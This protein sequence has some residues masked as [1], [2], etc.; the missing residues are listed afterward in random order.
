MNSLEYIAHGLVYALL[1][2]SPLART[3]PA[4]WLVCTERGKTYEVTVKELVDEKR[5]KF[6]KETLTDVPLYEGGKG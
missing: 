5:L 3:F 1:E 4:R 2:R 6:W